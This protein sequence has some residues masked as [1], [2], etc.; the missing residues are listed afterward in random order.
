MVAQNLYYDGPSRPAGLF[1]DCLTIPSLS[2][3]IYEGSFYGFIRSHPIDDLIGLRYV[4]SS[5]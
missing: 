5:L 2:R 4:S 1:D 3:N